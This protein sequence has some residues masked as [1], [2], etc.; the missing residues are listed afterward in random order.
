T[1]AA[2]ELCDAELSVLYLRE[3]EFLVPRGTGNLDVTQ[4]EFVRNNPIPVND[5]SLAGQALLTGTIVNVADTE[6]E[7]LLTPRRFRQA[8]GYHAILM[9]PML[10]EGRG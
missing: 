6:K 5:Q 2:S 1:R 8:L 3:G 4:S 9:V 7:T 10:R